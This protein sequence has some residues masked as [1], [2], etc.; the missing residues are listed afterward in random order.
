MCGMSRIYVI[1]NRSQTSMGLRKNEE[2]NVAMLHE[3]FKSI[4]ADLALVEGP[5]VPMTLLNN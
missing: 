5:Q 1:I 2:R 4:N 3:E